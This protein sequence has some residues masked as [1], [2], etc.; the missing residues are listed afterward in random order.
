MTKPTKENFFPYAFT[1]NVLDIL[2]RLREASLPNVI[3]ATV[4]V[5]IG[6]SEGNAHRTVAAL[7]FLDL[8]DDEGK[9]T[10]P[11]QNLAK[12][13]TEE[14]P[15][16][17]GNI[18]HNAYSE[19]FQIVNPETTSEVQVMDT[20]RGREPKSQWKQ[21]GNLF[22]GLCQEAGLIPGK[23]ATSNRSA[24]SI[25]KP[26]GEGEGR[27]KPSKFTSDA[28]IYYGHF[29][30]IFEQLPSYSNRSWNRITKEKWLKLFESMLDVLIDVED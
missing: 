20:F 16:V 25:S 8:I 15:S 29:Q 27:S 26:S 30:N 19:I 14:Y 3:D 10:E 28:S 24:T 6:V 2:R 17:L 18:I 13:S 22:I 9:Q 4:V 1:G 23:P 12:A 21:M 7:K 11:M 5:R